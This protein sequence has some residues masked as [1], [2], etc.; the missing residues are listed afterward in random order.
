MLRPVLSSVFLIFVLSACEMQAPPTATAPQNPV[1]PNAAPMQTARISE[2]SSTTTTTV[3]GNTTR[4]V[5][6]SSS[7]SINPGGLWGAFVSGA[8]PG[9]ANSAADYAGQWRVSSSDNRECR[10]NLMAPRTP[11]GPATVQM[12]GCFG[13]IFGITRWSLRGSELV[14][15]D[16]FGQKQISLRATGV[17]RLDGGGVIMWR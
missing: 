7:V 10:A 12:Q 6:E 17:N 8:A 4:T 14:L 1:M 15:T 9:A 11:S 2:S 16:A 3:E 13:D 5:T